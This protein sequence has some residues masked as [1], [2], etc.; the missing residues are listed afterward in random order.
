[1]K[2]RHSRIAILTISFFFLLIN[3]AHA[4]YDDGRGREWRLARVPTSTAAQIAQVCPQDG[5]TTCAGTPDIAGWV[6]GTDAQVIRLFGNFAPE[7]L[8]STTNGVAG[9]EYIPVANSMFGTFG[10]TAA[11][12][13]C[14]T[15]QGCFDFKEAIGVTASNSATGAPIAGRVITSNDDIFPTAGISVDASFTTATSTWSAIWQ[16]RATGL[17]NDG[18]YA[19]DDVGTSSSPYGGTVINVLA[20]DWYGGVRASTANVS[21]AALT[22]LPAGV[23]LGADGNVDIATGITAGTYNFG[24]RICALNNPASCDDAT[25][26]ITVKSFAI[27]AVNDQASVSFAYGKSNVVN[28]LTND[29][30]GGLSAN[31]A[32]VS[33]SQVSS[34]HPGITVD[35]NGMVNV[36]RDTTNGPHALVYQI[37]ERANATNCARATVALTSYSIVAVSDYWRL[38]SKTGATSPSVLAND[39][40]NGAAA[41]TATV[42]VSLVSPLSYG[43]TFS[44]ATGQFTVA[45]KTSSGTYNFI[46]RIC[47]INN[48]T[49][50]SSATATLELS[51]KGGY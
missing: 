26:N 40:F 32:I 17:G 50:C 43:I 45:P 48:P 46:Y 27:S 12:R 19:N 11:M 34:T 1:M 29:K 14:T 15:Y 22:A 31:S 39:A 13:G 41:T 36:A 16:W 33:V 8:T 7:I 25:V 21:L 35:A 5:Q 37:C 38:S 23:T 47:E 2:P 30:L 42:R 20:N 49:N 9:P 51:G 28:V 3:A 44:V 6:W 4:S 24:Y 10:I 18:I